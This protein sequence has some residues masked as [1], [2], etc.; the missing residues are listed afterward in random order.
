MVNELARDL[1]G[2]DDFKL[3]KFSYTRDELQVK[4]NKSDKEEK[5]NRVLTEDNEYEK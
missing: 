2:I 3:A 5:A 4:S 1:L